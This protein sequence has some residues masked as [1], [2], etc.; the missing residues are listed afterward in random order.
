MITFLKIH[1]HLALQSPAEQPLMEN[2]PVGIIAVQVLQDHDLLSPPTFYALVALSCEAQ[3]GVEP[4]RA[5]QNLL[6]TTHR[7]GPHT[8]RPGRTYS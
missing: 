7:C 4:H 1:R 6:T 3:H 5:P 8:P 2:N